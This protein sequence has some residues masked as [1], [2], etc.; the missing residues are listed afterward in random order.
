MMHL[1]KRLLK[2]GWMQWSS[3]TWGQPK[4]YAQSRSIS[5]ESGKDSSSVFP[6]QPASEAPRRSQA[7]HRTSFW[8]DSSKGL[9]SNTSHT[10][11]GSVWQ[12]SFCLLQLFP[13]LWPHQLWLLVCV[14]LPADAPLPV[15]G[16]ALD[17]FS[18]RGLEYEVMLVSLRALDNQKQRHHDCLSYFL[19]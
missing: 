9:P 14:C 8:S 7:P 11:D 16:M 2:K 18:L 19:H 17:L 5:W 3:L 4:R 1:L 6:T 15:S 10:K 13:K 12:T